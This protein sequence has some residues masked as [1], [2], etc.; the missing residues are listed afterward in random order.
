MLIVI[1]YLFIQMHLLIYL[2]LFVRWKDP[3]MASF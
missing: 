2:L 1:D 3:N